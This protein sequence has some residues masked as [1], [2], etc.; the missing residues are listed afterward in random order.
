MIA[1]QSPIH[2][3]TKPFRTV[4]GYAADVFD[5][6]VETNVPEE[7]VRQNFGALMA[8]ADEIV[9]ARSMSDLYCVVLEVTG[10]DL[11][12]ETAGA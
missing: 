9:G 8:R 1:T 12:L 11:M 5:V 6:L 2:F 3:T 4:S 10:C 7:L